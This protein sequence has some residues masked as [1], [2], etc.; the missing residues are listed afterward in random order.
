M[1]YGNR[2][3]PFIKYL[4]AGSVRA[5]LSAH[6]AVEPLTAFAHELASYDILP[7]AGK[8]AHADMHK[9]LDKASFGD[10][11]HPGK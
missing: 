10:L 4:S 5:D 3:R 7:G 1:K 8:Q 2:Y 6:M 11:N 9:V